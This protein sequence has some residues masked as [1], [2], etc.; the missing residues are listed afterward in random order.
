MFSKDE[1]S[2]EPVSD[3]ETT[4]TSNK[5][6]LT[7]YTSSRSYNY[8]ASLIDGY[9]LTAWARKKGFKTVDEMLMDE[10]CY[11]IMEFKKSFVLSTGYEF[12]QKDA[13][14]E[15]YE[16]IENNFNDQYEGTLTQDLYMMLSGFEYG[17]SISEKVYKLKDGNY[18][19]TR[20]KT[21]PPHDFLF[22][23]DFYGKLK[24]PDGI[25]QRQPLNAHQV[26]PRNKVVLFVHNK[27]FDNPFGV[28]DF[29]RCYRS[30]FCKDNAMKYWNIYLQRFASPFPVAKVEDT[31][32]ANKVNK[33]MKL[34]NSIQQSVSLIIPKSADVTL[35]KVGSD[36]GAE[37]DKAIE[38]YNQMIARALLLPDLMGFGQS[39][40]GGSY[41]LGQK[42]YQ[43]FVTI[44][45]T[46]RINIE[47]L[48]NEEV[49]KPLVIM[50][51]GEQ[52][53][54][55]V[56][57]FKPFTDD[58]LN[59][60]LSRF[61]DAVK[62]GMPASTE[63]W[64]DFRSKI[65]FE[66]IDEEELENDDLA[67]NLPGDEEE[68]MPNN[69]IQDEEPSGELV[70]EPT[71]PINPDKKTP[72]QLDNDVEEVTSTS[73]QRKD[74]RNIDAKDRYVVPNPE[75]PGKQGEPPST[76]DI[77][78][79]S[80]IEFGGEGSGNFGH[81]GIPGQVGGSS[82]SGGA[83]EG[84]SFHNI[85]ESIAYH[86]TTENAVSSIQE[87]GLDYA[88]NTMYGQ[89]IYLT[90]DS[91]STYG[92]TRIKMKLDPHTQLTIDRDIDT[93]RVLKELTGSDHPS[94]EMMVMK[95][96]Q[97]LRIN[98]EDSQHS[99]IVIYDKSIIHIGSISKI[100]TSPT[101]Y[102]TNEELPVKSVKNEESNTYRIYEEYTIKLSREPNKY[103]KR[104]D[105]V[106]N[107]IVLEKETNKTIQRLAKEFSYMLGY[108]KDTISKKGIIAENKI[109]EIDK[110]QL[111]GL[112]EIKMILS[113]DLK[114]IYMS[115]RKIAQKEVE[116]LPGYKKYDKQI[117]DTRLKPTEAIRIAN[118]LIDQR[119]FAAV[120]KIKD[121]L[122]NKAKT[123]LINGLEKGR[124]VNDI[125][126][127]LDVL[128]NSVNTGSP[129]A[130]LSTEPYLLNTIVQTN[131]TNFYNLARKQIANE[132]KYIEMMQYS[133][134]MDDRTTEICQELDGKTYKF[135]D[136]IWDSILPPNHFNC[137][138]MINY[139]T[140]IDVEEDKIIPD[141]DVDVSELAKDNPGSASFL[142]ED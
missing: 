104:V 142:G 15:I 28:S 23:T 107:Q 109:S 100:H 16:F 54:Y 102:R 29:A 60:K 106:Q 9:D 83:P 32:G 114:T 138:S 45:S 136:P 90:T 80:I 44:C 87:K 3:K 18:W 56:F 137:R 75:E 74:S 55:P 131:Y 58:F 135:D 43:M 24:D 61:L 30:W 2:K 79:H 66:D 123:I 48:I 113:Q 73:S 93:P 91:S 72:E 111:K 118:E 19:N 47:E 53:N 98:F 64:N 5:E 124:S 31:F 92:N 67:M 126:Q 46:I 99:Y 115:S 112:T 121:D 57:K 39:T 78:K 97:S 94:P 103:E 33:L 129:V 6:W 34:L 69:V 134:I 82:P 85:G 4:N 25:V 13:D 40:G 62:T 52:E 68:V 12:Q 101:T 77:K 110:L 35:E 96:I 86:N 122:L 130:N 10:N 11:G 42:H 17:F 36:S 65:D 49:I 26:I 27:R 71:A 140:E 128:F 116:S 7:E 89:G 21:V 117:S 59:D 141:E 41:S 76:K 70:D 88:N 1:D 95:G 22:Y 81:S 119:T 139:I 132:N 108:L 127:Q 14:E 125:N 20:L 51:F 105:F 63:D 37:Y 133:A 8:P 38:R 84:S 50:N 120:G